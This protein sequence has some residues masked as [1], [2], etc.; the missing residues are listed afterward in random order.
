MLLRT[1]P[2]CRFF[3]HMACQHQ[4]VVDTGPAAREI[5]CSVARQ[6]YYLCGRD[7]RFWEAKPLT[8]WERVLRWLRRL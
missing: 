1:C 8:R 2:T 3:F 7:A 5:P 4:A 6:Q